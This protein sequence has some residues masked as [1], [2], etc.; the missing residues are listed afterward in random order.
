MPTLPVVTN[1][2]SVTVGLM[3]NAAAAIIIAFCKAKFDIDFAGQE[4][5]LQV[6]A[7]G[8]GYLVAGVKV[9]A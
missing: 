2:A 6:L 5:N 8:F 3:A 1:H 4:A 7:T 9:E